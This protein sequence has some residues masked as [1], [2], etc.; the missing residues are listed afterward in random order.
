MAK[1]KEPAPATSSTAATRTPRATPTAG[2]SGS[3]LRAGETGEQITIYYGAE[4]LAAHFW[5]HGCRCEPFPVPDVFKSIS[6][7]NP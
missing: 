7:V 5:C 2:G 1:A 3:A 4:Y 6:V